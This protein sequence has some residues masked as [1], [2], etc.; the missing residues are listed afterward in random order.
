MGLDL[1]D[2]ELEKLD[3]SHF[4]DL[5]CKAARTNLGRLECARLKPTVL[6][7]EQ[8]TQRAKAVVELLLLKSQSQLVLPLGDFPDISQILLRV[9]RS[10]KINVEEFADLVRFNKS[11][12]G[13]I[14]F[15][16]RH[17]ALLPV[18][19]KLLKELEGIEAWA[20]KTYP[21][22]G[23]QGDIADSAS[24]DLRALRKLSKDLHEKIKKRLEDFLHNPKLAELMQ[25]FYVTV[26]DGRYVLPVKANFKGRVPGI[27]HDVSHT[28]AT[29]FVEPEEIVDWN[30]QLKVVEKEIQKEIERILDGVVDL[31]QDY[32]H[33]WLANQDTVA[34]A[35]L[36]SASQEVTSA[37]GARVCVPEWGQR[38]CFEQLSHPLLLIQRTVVPNTLEWD[39]GLVLSGPNT[40]GKTVLLKSIGLSVVLT[41]CGLPVPAKSMTIPENMHRL[42][43][44]IGDDQNIEKDLSTFSAHL[45]A[46]KNILEKCRSGDL[47]LLDEIATGTSPEDGQPL[48]QSVLEDLL[49]KNVRFLATTHYGALKQFAMANEKCRIAAM[50]F[51]T[52]TRKATYQV[53]LDIP[54][55]SSAFETAESLGFDKKII[56]RARTLKGD[57]SEDLDKAIRNLEL[58]RKKLI[59]KEEELESSRLELSAAHLKLEAQIAE[60]KEKQRV[61]L[62]QESKCILKD[63]QLLR[64]ELAQSV[65][66]ASSEDLKS[67]GQ[68]L[69][70]KISDGADWIRKTVSE[71]SSEPELLQA[72]DDA[73]LVQDALVEIENLGLGIIA[74]KPKD[75]SEKAL[76]TVQV[77][78][79]KTRVSR[80]R[81]KRAS[82]ER[83]QQHQAR[84][85]SISASH[86]AKIQ[87]SSQ[88][89]HKSGSGIC[90]VRGKNLEEALR[91][92]ESA[93]ND[94]LHEDV[95]SITI[96]HGHGSDKLKDSLRDYIVK[97]REDLKFRPGSWPGEGGD[98]VTVVEK[99]F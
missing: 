95:H 58:A 57:V 2:R 47:V 4:T 33:H 52:K 21:L 81:L 69:F 49:E 9:S 11:V 27:I 96:I 97:R 89:T 90:D 75:L 86:G 48:A 53:I 91:K 42:F 30:N 82:K 43:V 8:A 64:D 65:K 14:V 85:A 87:L 76:I 70:S 31:T 50:A 60:Y 5:L 35:D 20:K 26:R 29:L 68:K 51:D 78:D 41:W 72:L 15:L 59:E 13:L 73:E 67:G 39:L 61:G 37:W 19:N 7:P 40:G 56:S 46:L 25:D 71:V 94:L 62:S 22:L 88:P 98:G 63:F 23:P 32:V 54:G 34:L 79:L 44:D 93:L 17:M 66:T 36:L 55:E 10:G 6:N 38:L 77:G 12:Q 99:V 80:K 28:E 1:S 3:W 18:T 16:S 74:E 84:K 92:V 83:V 45:V 24:E